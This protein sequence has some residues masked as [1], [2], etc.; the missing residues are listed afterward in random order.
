MFRGKFGPI[1]KKCFLILACI[2]FLG[3]TGSGVFRMINSP[4][5]NVKDQTQ[6][7]NKSPEERLKEAAKGYETVLQKEPNNRFALEKLVEIR[8][9]LKEF[10]GALESTAKL[11]ELYPENQQY[12]QVL[13]Y[14]KDN[15]AQISPSDDNSSPSAE[16]GS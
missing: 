7:E 8:L 2:S 6:T 9:Q 13:E 3:A 5:T 15:L 10:Q 14:I 12:Q 4:Q 11:V 16:E 1:F